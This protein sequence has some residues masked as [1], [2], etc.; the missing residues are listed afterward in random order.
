MLSIHIAKTNTWVL[1][2]WAHTMDTTIFTGE[3][4]N[5][6]AYVAPARKLVQFITNFDSAVR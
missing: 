3:Y 5:G 6:A 2:H 4:K 1:T